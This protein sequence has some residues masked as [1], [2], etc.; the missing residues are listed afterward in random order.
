MH[1]SSVILSLVL[2]IST[3]ALAQWELQKSGSTANL[4]GIHAVSASIAWAS[5]ADGTILRTENGGVDW[6]RCATPPGAEKLDFRGVWAWDAKSAMVLSSGPGEQSRVYETKDSC[7]HWT[8]MVR[9]SDKDGF[10]DAMTFQ[11]GDFGML[12]DQRT[13]VLIGDPVHNHFYTM[14]MIFGHGWFNDDASCVARPGEAA[15]AASNTSAFVFG[16]R[17][18][19]I[20]TGGTAGPRA[21]LSPLLANRDTAQGCLDVTLPLASGAESA[22]AFSVFFSDAQHGVTVGG[23]Y[24]QPEQTAG[25]AAFTTDGG[26]HW[27]AATKPPHGYRSTVTWYADGKVW[28]AVGTNGSDISRDGGKTWQ[29]LDNANWNALS[30]P[31]IVGPKGSIGKLRASAISQ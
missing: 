16:S 20:V 17:R 14:T 30:L 19:I 3:N 25:T 27:T 31:Y 9:N 18:Y 6:Q 7:S 29:A 23:D 28:I 8:E 21:L 13:G 4:R 2:L 10:W 1:K 15:F 26:R 11:A 22:G 24:K 12:G 5:G